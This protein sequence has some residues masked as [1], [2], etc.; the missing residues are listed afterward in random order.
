MPCSPAETRERHD[1]VFRQSAYGDGVELDRM[2]S[3]PAARVDALDDLLATITTRDAA[4]LVRIE[5]VDVHVDAPQ[6]CVEER[7]RGAGEQEPVRGEGDVPDAGHADELSH[8]E[9]QVA[10]HER[11]AAG[12]TELRDAHAGGGTREALDLLER[13]DLRVRDVRRV[14]LRH[15]VE[16]SD[17]AAIGDADPEVV[18]DTSERVDEHGTGSISGPRPEIGT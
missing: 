17:V 18:V 8:E 2:E 5:R 4:K 15:A 11:L 1:V 7:L 14:L 3:E 16:A 9:R 6:A 12:Q 10:A 13:E